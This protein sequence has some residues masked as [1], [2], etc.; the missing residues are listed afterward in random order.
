MTTRQRPEILVA[1][2]E[3]VPAPLQR[4]CN[5]QTFEL[6]GGLYIA[7]ALCLAGFIA[8]L[9]LAFR[10]HM[11]VSFGV[12]LAFLGAYFGVPA[13]LPYAGGRDGR[14]KA[15]NWFEFRHRGIA[16]A[17]GRTSAREATILVLLLP[18]LILCFGIAVVTI[19]AL[20]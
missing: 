18:F 10:G 11:A 5:D 2:D 12:I 9:S 17:T 19:A 7:M 15:L 14:A 3:I 1:R 20:V 8:V 6:P 16:T 13:L 4:S